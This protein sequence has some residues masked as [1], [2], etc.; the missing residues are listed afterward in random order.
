MTNCASTF[1]LLNLY[2]AST[3]PLLIL[4]TAPTPMRTCRLMPS[5]GV[6]VPY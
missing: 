4:N 2:F 5:V 3:D 6:G 1:L